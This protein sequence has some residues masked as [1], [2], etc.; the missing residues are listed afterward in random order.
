MLQK[1]FLCLLFTGITILG[2]TAQ[3]AAPDGFSTN[4]IQQFQRF[5]ELPVEKVYLHLD[6]PYYSAGEHIWYAAYLTNDMLLPS[7]YS[8]FIYVEL[9]N[10]SDSVKCRYKIR[11][12]SLGFAGNILLPADFPA[13]DYHLRAYT[14][15]MQNDGTDYFFQRDL[16]IGNAIDRTIQSAATYEQTGDKQV[17]AT[18]QFM[19]SE[20]IAFAGK[21]VRYQLFAGNKL[22]RSQSASI[23]NNGKLRLGVDYDPNSARQYR[24]ELAFDDNTYSYQTTF[25]LP[26]N[27]T[28]FDIQFFPEGGTLLDNNLCNVAF[29]AVG[30]NGLS[31]EVR[32]VVYTQHGDSVTAFRSEHKGMGVFPLLVQKAAGN[33]YAKV[34]VQGSS[35]VKTIPLPPVAESGIGLSITQH[36][37]VLRYQILSTPEQK[38]SPLY[39]LAHQPGKMKVYVPNAD[40]H[41]MG[42]ISAEPFSTG[43]VHF[44][45]LNSQGDALSERLVFIR[46]E[47]ESRLSITSDAAEYTP[48]QKVR[49]TIGLKGADTL[50]GKFSVAVTEDRS[51]KLDSLADNI[52]SNL[53]LTSDLKGYIE[54]PNYYFNHPDRNTDHAL[55]LVMMTHGWTRY[56]VPYILH[57][58]LPATPFF[59][60]GSQSLSGKVIN[61]VGKPAKGVPVIAMASK[62]MFTKEVTTNEKG[63]YIIG[64]ISFPDSTRI[65]LQ[66]RSKRGNNTIEIIPDEERYPAVENLS[67]FP[68]TKISPS[69][70]DDYMSTM[71]L[72]FH[73]EGSERVFHLKEV[74]VTASKSDQEKYKSIYAGLARL[75]NTVDGEQMK[76]HYDKGETVLDI[77]RR[78]PG[79]QIVDRNIIVRNVLDGPNIVIDDIP[80][81]NVDGDVVQFLDNINA[82]DVEAVALLKGALAGS[83]MQGLGVV[84]T[85]GGS[86]GEGSHS[87]AGGGGMGGM[88]SVILIQRRKVETNRPAVTPGLVILHP[89][90]YYRP[91]QFYSPVYETPAQIHNPNPDFRTTIY[92]NPSIFVDKTNSSTVSF[93]TADNPG[94][95]TVTVEGITNIGETIYQE[96]KVHVK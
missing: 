16:H 14:W 51:V 69:I 84:N 67:P 71:G 62:R 83:Y 81:P 54:E 17:I 5:N 37:N 42:A 2:I 89:L 96:T 87:V 12:D 66:S 35:L 86:D 30:Q 41:W 9:I 28:A 52:C 19:S 78:F 36:N 6:K 72:K 1:P 13:G 7:P 82:D 95:Y 27:N 63:E 64:G 68:D 48:R 25:Y 58:K 93:Y 22:L 44:L 73:Y 38:I 21:R 90:G 61:A 65:L 45:L 10:K 3:T 23:D 11:R 18:I 70:M 94:S 47:P 92:W 15:W 40:T 57:G 79:V 8:H 29:K 56:S 33:Y 80:T 77:V 88:P 34:S 4:A 46:K 74:Q 53:L 75:G 55:D 20:N 24:I 43:I 85:G 59:L 60:E 31:V 91:A 76:E 39:L 26:K 32:G 49:L 50:Q